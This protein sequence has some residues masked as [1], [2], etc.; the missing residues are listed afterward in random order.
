MQ[1]NV[2]QNRHLDFLNE[3][4]VFRVSL[5]HIEDARWLPSEEIHARNKRANV[6]WRRKI[7]RAL[8]ALRR[9]VG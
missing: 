4:K 9:L 8:N 2:G 3:N 1:S 6:W 5:R 7:L